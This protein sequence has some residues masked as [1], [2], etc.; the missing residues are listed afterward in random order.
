MSAHRE[1]L[2]KLDA[3]RGVRVALG[4]L[5]ALIAAHLV[6]AL[7]GFGGH[8]VA[9]LFDTGVYDGV[10]VGCAALCLARAF[11]GHSQRL[12]WLCLG[13][14]LSC[15]AT[16]EIL[17]SIS[18]SLAPTVQSA[19][20]LCLYVSAYV[21]IVLLGRRLVR[22]FQLSMWL[23]GL[24]GALA[25]GALGAAALATPG[26]LAPR[27]G[28][29]SAALDVVYPFA[30][31]LLV[32]LVVTMLALGGWRVYRSFLVIALGFMLM[33]AADSAYLYQEAHG[34]YVVG[35]PL[36]SMWLFSTVILAFAAWQPDRESVH[37]HHSL[38]AIMAAPVSC[39]LIAI[40][41]LVYG[42]LQGIAGTSVWLAAATL[43]IVLARLLATANE[44][45]RLIASSS[46]L[47][48][49]DP[50]TGL[51]N[52]RALL[53]DLEREAARATASD[54]TLLL[55]FDL[56][57]FKRYN[58]TFGHPAGDALLA[59]L[60]ARLAE[61]AQG[62]GRVYRLGGDEFCALLPAA[63]TP[64]QTAA[65]LTAT[66]LESG[67]HFTIGAC[68][69]EVLVGAEARE[70][71]QALRI[72]D[73]RLY[74]QK[75]LLSDSVRPE[76]RD[77]LL[78]LLRERDPGLDTHVQQVARLAHRLGRELDMEEHQLRTLVAAAELHDVGKVAIPEA[79]LD[80]PGPLDVQERA[81]LER[82]ATIGERIIASAPTGR[83]VAGIVRAT[84]ERYDG[85]GYP[86]GLAGEQIPL[87]A[88]IIAICDAYDAMITST[89]SY[90]AALPAAQARAEL[91]RCAGS[92]F[93]PQLTA[94][95]LA[96][97]EQEPHPHLGEA[98]QAK[99]GY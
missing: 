73:Q 76:W 2:P 30:D 3:P 48:N 33:A 94:V 65:D 25:V 18:E 37:E 54:P 45:L 23:D 32:G 93:D 49:R 64:Q 42:S 83:T 87:E 8:M 10:M 40:G 88:R 22:H 57:G 4:V 61:R 52:R 82:H 5:L 14:G 51:G 56:N 29:V 39:A 71:A 43:V 50:L 46:E 59:R 53:A 69:G 35:T 12:A 6:H 16:G 66:L 11:A 20:Y 47:A 90:H 96:I 28:G 98:E 63:R 7:T 62:M 21:A 24:I 81:F 99:S 55:L 75:T 70:V 34:G 78:G 9:N 86:D 60:G 38:S 36:D 72:A 95:F 92:Q 26:F 41:V 27:D 68:Y 67:E 84:H 74:A 17:S 58:D 19:L 91:R 85:Q 31:V 15:D 97:L 44:N 89:R 79:I 13:V 1:R 80:K 77:V